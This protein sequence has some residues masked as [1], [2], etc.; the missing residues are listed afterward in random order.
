VVADY[1]GAQARPF[2]H[3]PCA[4]APLRSLSSIARPATYQEY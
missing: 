3:R 2:T 4:P 1:V